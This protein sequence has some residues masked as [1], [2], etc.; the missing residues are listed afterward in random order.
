M[1]TSRRW[2]N[3]AWRELEAGAERQARDKQ[4]NRLLDQWKLNGIKVKDLSVNAANNKQVIQD[5]MDYDKGYKN[6]LETRKMENEILHKEVREYKTSKY[7]KQKDQESG[8]KTK[9]IKMN[10]FKEKINK[11]SLENATQ[12]RNRQNK[13]ARVQ[14]D[15]TEFEA[16]RYGMGTMGEE[17]NLLNIEDD[18]NEQQNRLNLMMD[19]EA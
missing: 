1:L 3:K 10:P 6:R 14:P 7:M 2:R 16:D 12:F 4:N 8:L 13:S 17:T 19:M 11:E 9:M 5:K 15:H 18:A